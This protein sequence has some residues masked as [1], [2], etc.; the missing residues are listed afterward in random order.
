MTLSRQRSPVSAGTTSHMNGNGNGTSHNNEQLYHL[1]NGD[2]YNVNNNNNSGST[3][4][5]SS[6]KNFK[7][8]AIIVVF[9]GL[10]FFLERTERANIVKQGNGGG[11]GTRG[12]AYGGGGGVSKGLVSSS[13]YNASTPHDL[14]GMYSTHN[15]EKD[16]LPS[17]TFILQPSQEFFPTICWLMSFPN[18]G[19]SYTMTMVARA[20]NRSFASNYGDEVTASDQIETLSIYPRRPEG[21][22]WT[23]LINKQLVT[24]PRELPTDYVLTKTHCG[25]RCINCGPDDYI[26]SSK[27]FLTRCAS[28]SARVPPNRRRIEVEYPPER[29]HK[30]IHLIRNPFHNII[31]RFHLDRKHYVRSNKTDWLNDHPN[32]ATGFQTWCKGLD[33]EYETQ[34]KNHFAELS[35]SGGGTADGVDSGD[36]TT[37][38]STNPI[39]DAPCHGEFYKYTQWH[40]L[41][42]ESIDIIKRDHHDVPVLTV[43]YEDYTTNFDETTKEMLKFMNLEFVGELR[44]FEPRSDYDTYFTSKQIV[45][46]KNLIQHVASERTWEQVKHYFD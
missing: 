27:V 10:Y 34:D 22:Y 2:R 45:Q 24:H 6:R 1:S 25:S 30:A 29:V 38:S 20:S 4:S 32:D 26:E 18:S 13:Y 23:G 11:G 14:V 35:S 7:L 46:V 31:A 5:S 21:P 41:V 12:K 3:S 19:T 40:N 15:G 37:T 16:K 33:D 42:H 43:H 8:F 44:P 17:Q 28:G 36:S 9:C 39:L